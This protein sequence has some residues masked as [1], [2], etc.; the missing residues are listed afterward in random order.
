MSHAQFAVLV[1]ETVGQYLGRGLTQHSLH[2]D[3]EQ[4][5]HAAADLARTYQPEHP[6]SPRSRT[7]YR[8]DHDNYTVVVQGRT[9]AFYFRVQVADVFV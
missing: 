4:A 3:R 1:E 2:P 8:H 7:V 6:R 5:R 9:R